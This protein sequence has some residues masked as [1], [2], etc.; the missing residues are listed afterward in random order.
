[1]FVCRCWDRSL[2]ELKDSHP[3][4][5]TSAPH[6]VSLLSALVTGLDAM[7]YELSAE[8]PGLFRTMK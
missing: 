6:R 2:S 5:F 3:E 4:L 1:M 8:E 7:H